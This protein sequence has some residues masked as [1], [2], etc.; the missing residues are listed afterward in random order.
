MLSSYI[1]AAG[2]TLNLALQPVSIG[3][4][5]KWI[6]HGLC[7]AIARRG[8]ASCALLA[9]GEPG[10]VLG[11]RRLALEVFILTSI[12][13]ISLMQR[14]Y[15]AR[16]ATLHAASGDAFVAHHTALL[17]CPCSLA[18]NSLRRARHQRGDGDD[19]VL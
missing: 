18:A 9:P 13:Y 6:K 2:S 1:E 7:C 11:M 17:H 5:V 19:R 12:C 16:R 8:P 4:H 3:V 10:W 15:V 14:Y